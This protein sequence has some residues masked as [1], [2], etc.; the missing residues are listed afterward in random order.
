MFIIK[1]NQNYG[2]IFLI[3]LEIGKYIFLMETADQK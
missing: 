2:L 1:P 3:V